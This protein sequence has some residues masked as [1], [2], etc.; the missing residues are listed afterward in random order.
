MFLSQIPQGVSPLS[1]EQTQQVDLLL[2]SLTPVQQAWISGYLAASANG[3]GSN[4]VSG[5][6]AAPAAP[7]VEPSPLTILYGSQTGNAKSVASD[8]AA[9]AKARGLDVKLLDMGDYKPKQ[10]KDEKFL[11][12]VVSTYGEGEPP[13]NAEKLHAFLSGKKAPKLNGTQV[14]VIG[15]GDSSYEFFCQ[16]ATDF[17]ERLSALGAEVI[18]ERALL[19]VDYDDAAATWVDGAV[20]AY[21]PLLKAANQAAAPAAAPGLSL[22]SSAEESPYNKKNPFV[23]EVAVVQKITGRDSTKDV[24][25]VEISL[26][27]SGLHYRAGDALGVYFNNDGEEV[28]RALALLKLD[29]SS[30]IK[31]GSEGKKLR[32]ALIEDFEL[33]Q[34][35]P[36]FVQKFADATANATLKKLG[37]DKAALREYI[38]DRQIFDVIHEHPAQIDAQAL[39]DCLRKVQP[40]LYS[41]ASS[42]AE[43][44]EEVHLTVGVVAF[45]ANEQNRLGG[46]S[47]FLGRR[48]VEGDSVRVYV[49]HNDNFRL[50][51]NPDT[52]TIMIGPGTGI[53]PF[54]AFLQERD[55]DG[56]DGDNWMIFGNPHFTQDFLYQVEMQGYL[57]SGLLNKLSVAFSRDQAE[58]I[59]VQDRITEN[60]AELYQWLE[61][62]AHLYICGDGSRMAKDVHEA[63]Q[64]VLVEHGG[65]SV[66]AA[67]A[68]LEK[69][70]DNKRYQK[71]VY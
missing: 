33:T 57:K 32:D 56:A 10:L 39:I 64:G 5:T 46:C 30:E 22:V 9:K 20:D 38:M 34:G 37:E 40:R 51:Q 6:V 62:G 70:R 7:A 43:V 69:L 63:L 65:L 26:E 16:T 28:D 49:E 13:E 19:D 1:P 27:E 11:A 8:L 42:Q 68:Y 61:K 29:G 55:A 47:G 25:H 52:P 45:E 50:P 48:S 44:E 60:G 54:R 59:Y 15:L 31:V 18:V 36:G 4:A 35:Y 24:R 17:E 12:I 2:G 53:A 23:A 58:K 14:A 67:E 41:I 71:D 21:E 66:D 3:A